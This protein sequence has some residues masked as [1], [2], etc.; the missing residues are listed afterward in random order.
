M[1]SDAACYLLDIGQM[2]RERL[3]EAEHCAK[4]AKD[5]RR[6]FELGRYRAYREV[7]ALMLSQADA[8]G[9]PPGNLSLQGL[10]RSRDLGC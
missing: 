4:S 1:N 8:F 9:I 6:E 5:S 3:T 2:L 10:D 7:L